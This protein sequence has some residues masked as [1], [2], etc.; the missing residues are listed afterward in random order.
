MESDEKNGI[1]IG[2]DGII[3]PKPAQY[4][5]VISKARNLKEAYRFCDVKPLTADQ[6]DYYIPFEARQDAILGVSTQ[7]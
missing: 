6:M 2:G 7:S 3:F 4:A 5:M 1:R